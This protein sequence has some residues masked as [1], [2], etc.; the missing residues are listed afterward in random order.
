MVLRVAFGG[1]FAAIAVLVGV[2]LCPTICT[3]LFRIVAGFDARQSIVD[4]F[5][6]SLVAAGLAIHTAVL[7]ASSAEKTEDNISWFN[8]ARWRSVIFS[9]ALSI[10][11]S[12]LGDAPVKVLVA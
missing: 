10:A 11:L 8:R 6:R 12:F 1:I 9:L 3:C 4:H 5:A 2:I 7:W